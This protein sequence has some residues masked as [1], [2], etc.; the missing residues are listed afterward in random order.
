[1]QSMLNNT[2][3]LIEAVTSQ[4]GMF[5]KQSMINYTKAVKL[6]CE[7][8]KYEKYPISHRLPY[9]NCDVTVVMSMQNIHTIQ[10]CTG[11][12]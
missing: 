4:V 1:M 11:W 7:Y 8:A 6:V 12:P 10:N 2:R 9:I 5:G 3:G